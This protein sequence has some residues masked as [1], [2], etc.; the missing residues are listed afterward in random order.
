MA[1]T[2]TKRHQRKKSKERGSLIKKYGICLDG[3]TRSRQNQKMSLI[4]WVNAA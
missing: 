4:V 1:A 3:L 2:T